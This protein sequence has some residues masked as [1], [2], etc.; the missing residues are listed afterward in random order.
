MKKLTDYN[1]YELSAGDDAAVFY[2]IPAP[3]ALAAQAVMDAQAILH[4]DMPCDNCLNL[5][6]AGCG[7]GCSLMCDKYNLWAAQKAYEEACK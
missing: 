1:S 4:A 2:A 7:K 5:V 3:V 6:R